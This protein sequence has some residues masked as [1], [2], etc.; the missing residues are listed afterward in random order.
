MAHKA[1][2]TAVMSHRSGETEDSTIAD[3]AVATNC[4]QIKTG[5]LARSDRTAKY[6]QLLRIEE[7]LGAQAKY[8]GRDGAEGASLAAFAAAWHLR[9]ELPANSD[10]E[11]RAAA[12]DQTTTLTS[13]DRRQRGRAPGR[14][15]RA[16]G[17]RRA[18][19]REAVLPSRIRPR[20]SGRRLRANPGADAGGDR[21]PPDARPQQGPRSHRR[22][23]Y[24][25]EDRPVPGIHPQ[26]AAGE[27]RAVGRGRPRA[28]LGAGQAGLHPPA[29]ARPVEALRRRTS[30]RSACI[31]SRS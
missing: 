15:R 27:A 13:H 14:L 31:R 24:A 1:G 21:L 26:S 18:R 2:Y 4:G 11:S 8:A 20:V 12:M 3:L 5:S 7:E 23:P 29:R 28:V 19:G 25:R 17:R 22:H 16:I 9:V 10:P 6:N 30:P